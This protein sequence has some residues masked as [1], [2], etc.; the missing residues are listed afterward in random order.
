MSIFWRALISA[1]RQTCGEVVCCVPGG[2]SASERALID[3]GARIVHYR[4]DRKGIDPFRDLLT[5]LDLK[6]VMRLEKPVF[7][8]TATIKAVIYGCLAAHAAGAPCVFAAI[9]GLGYAFETDTFPKK[10]INRISRIL[11]KNSLKHAN[12][13]FFQNRDDI[14]LFR[15]SGILSPDSAIFL[16]NGTGV[17]T[18]KF[19]PAPFPDFSDGTVFLLVG[20]LLEAKGIRDYAG[21]AYLLKRK[22]PKA[23]FLLLGPPEEGRGSLSRKDMEKFA[24]EGVEYLGQAA[25]VRPALASAHVIVLPSWREGTPTAVME[26]MAMGRPCVVTDVPGCREVVENGENGWLA[27][28]RDPQSLAEAME[29]FLQRPELIVSMGQKSRRVVEEKFDARTVAVAMVEDMLNNCHAKA[30]DKE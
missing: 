1:W 26:A 25:D 2:D 29:R 27:A 7:V 30:A 8:F 21:A 24:K 5:Y 19:T 22:Y 20:R 10:I 11:Y 12:G 15:K 3:L 16:A 14:A 18:E 28:P 17:D 23:R 6:R 9:T 13:V 4:L